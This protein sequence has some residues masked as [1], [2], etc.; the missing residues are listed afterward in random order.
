MYHIQYRKSC[1][2]RNFN[3]VYH[4]SFLETLLQSRPTAD[5]TM[6]TGPTGKEKKNQVFLV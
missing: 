2:A 5:A 4:L 6:T 3:P 1:G